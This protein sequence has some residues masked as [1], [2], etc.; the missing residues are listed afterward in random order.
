MEEDVT[1]TNAQKITF[2]NFK[3]KTNPKTP[4]PFNTLVKSFK[5]VITKK[6]TS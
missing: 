2:K 3:I 5:T 4:M 1:D 6:K